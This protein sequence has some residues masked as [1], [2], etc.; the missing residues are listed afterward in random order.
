MQRSLIT[1][2]I[3][4]VLFGIAIGIFTLLRIGSPFILGVIGVLS[5][6]LSLTLIDRFWK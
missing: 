3:A 2:L 6:I 5:Y 4:F 1:A